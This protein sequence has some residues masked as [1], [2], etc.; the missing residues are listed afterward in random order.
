MT[1]VDGRCGLL[2]IAT[3]WSLATVATPRPSGMGLPA[4]DIVRLIT[5]GPF[6]QPGNG[7]TRWAD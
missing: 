2:R 3:S 1:V 7:T 5:G 4:A 6:G